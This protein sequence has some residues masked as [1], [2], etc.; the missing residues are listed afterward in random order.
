MHRLGYTNNRVEQALP[1]VWKPGNDREQAETGRENSNGPGRIMIPIPRYFKIPTP[2]LTN[3][4]K[5]PNTDI[6]LKY[7]H[8]PISSTEPTK[9]I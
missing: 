4:E 9:K 2:Y 7:R 8:R 6:D 5:I 1:T 3:T